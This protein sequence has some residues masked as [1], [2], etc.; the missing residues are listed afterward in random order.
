MFKSKT[1]LKICIA[2][3]MLAFIFGCNKTEPIRSLAYFQ[4]LGLEKTFAVLQSC[5]DE[6]KSLLDKKNA[7]GL[8]QFAKSSQFANCRVAFKFAASEYGKNILLKANDFKNATTQ[9][10]VENLKKKIEA[11]F[12]AKWKGIHPMI[13]D[14]ENNDIQ[15]LSYALVVVDQTAANRSSRIDINS[16]NKSK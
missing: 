9:V 7:E 3:A 13:R 12:E 5:A 2:F 4:G 1:K 14:Y 11:E 16:W 10:E 6:K 8:D 15:P